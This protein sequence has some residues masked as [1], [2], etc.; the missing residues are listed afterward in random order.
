MAWEP[1]LAAASDG[2]SVNL[3]DKLLD[4]PVGYAKS[5]G[6]RFTAVKPG[7]YHLKKQGHGPGA[8]G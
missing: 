8:A 7:L 3:S 2:A 6:I 5:A 1:R 4:Y